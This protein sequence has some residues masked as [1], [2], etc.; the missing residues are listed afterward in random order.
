M[1]RTFK[2]I[3][4]KINQELCYFIVLGVIMILATCLRLYRLDYQGLWYDEAKIVSMSNEFGIL[5]M[6]N[7]E[8]AAKPVFE[9]FVLRPWIKL[10]GLSE[11]AVRLPA[12]ILGVFSVLLIYKLGVLVFNRRT[13]LI[14]AFLL[15]ISPSSIYYS[16]Q[17]FYSC[18]E[19]TIV[20]LSMFLFF[21]VLR[22]KRT[23]LALT[24][25]NIIGIYTFVSCL[26]VVMVQILAILLFYTEDKHFLKRWFFSQIFVFFAFV[27]WWFIFSRVSPLQHAFYWLSPPTIKTLVGTLENFS[28]GVYQFALGGAG[29]S[30]DARYLFL[31]RIIFLAYILLSFY[32]I[33]KIKNEDSRS[34]ANKLIV[35]L[36]LIVPVGILFIF[37]KIFFPA[38]AYRFIMYCMPAYYLLV[39]NGLSQ[40][41]AITVRSTI[42]IVIAFMHFY[43]LRIIYEP[44]LTQIKKI[45]GWREIGNKVRAHIQTNDIIILSPLRQAVPFWYYYKPEERTNRVIEEMSFEPKEKWE[46]V[47]NDNN[48]SIMGPQLGGAMK[49]VKKYEKYFEQANT[50]W[51]IISPYWPGQGNSKEY[52]LN[53]FLQQRVL[54]SYSSYPFHGVEVY[55][56]CQK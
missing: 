32:S 23:L 1:H 31:P 30:V 21:K 8:D 19:I 38:Y 6:W 53:Y 55:R 11:Y 26:F 41:S 42:I 46:T 3:Y 10:F 24:I 20:L 47:Y 33:W 2:D 16:Q 52:L 14:S 28:H 56:F 51:L 22:D 27:I 40:I 12:V 29:F 44:A 25:V 48:I 43:P 7:E 50:I 36:W 37:S 17:A 5:N 49:F 4:R 54:K 45:D 13:G 15:A 18:M 34:R 35:I 9:I 39:A